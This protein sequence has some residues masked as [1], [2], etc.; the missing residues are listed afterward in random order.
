[1]ELIA[2]YKTNHVLQST[3]LLI[4]HQLRQSEALYYYRSSASPRLSQAPYCGFSSEFITAYKA[5]QVLPPTTAAVWHHQG[6]AKHPTT[7]KVWY[8]HDQA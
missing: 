6:Q 1:M 5:I 7:I 4:Q 8:H 3:T 2:T